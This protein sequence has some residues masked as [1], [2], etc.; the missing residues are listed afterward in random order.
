MQRPEMPRPPAN[1]GAD[2]IAGRRYGEST[3]GP[4]PASLFDV[5]DEARHRRDDGQRLALHATHHGWRAAAERVIAE[6]AEAGKPFTIDD[7]TDRI[8]HALASSPNALGS[9]MTSAARQ[10]LIRKCGYVQSRRESRRESR[11][12]GYVFEWIG[13]AARDAS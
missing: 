13:V 11:A 3:S 4:I 2:E 9:L 10:G 7:V 6:Y 12:G 5:L 1:R 8:G